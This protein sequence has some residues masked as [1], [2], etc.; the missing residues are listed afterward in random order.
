LRAVIYISQFQCVFKHIAGL[1]NLVADILSRFPFRRDVAQTGDKRAPAWF[2]EALRA[3]GKLDSLPEED[4]LVKASSVNTLAEAS[5][6]SSRKV[7]A[8][9]SIDLGQGN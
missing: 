4:V 2:I 1:A 6:G 7:D 3:A 5:S 9:E 8:G